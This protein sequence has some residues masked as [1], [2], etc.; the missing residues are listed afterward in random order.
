[1]LLQATWHSPSH[2]L[3]PVSAIQV[4]APDQTVFVGRG[5]AFNHI[6]IYAEA[7]TEAES[8]KY[9]PFP[10]FFPP[11][12]KTDRNV[13]LNFYISLS[14]LKGQLLSSY[15]ALFHSLESSGSVKS[16]GSSTH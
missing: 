9:K 1:M 6:K 5:K 10:L 11:D 12:L 16:R 2:L 8:N 3:Y 14:H 4:C 13:Q 7:K 15:C